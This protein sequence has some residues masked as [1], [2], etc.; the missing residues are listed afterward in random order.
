ME[1]S[2]DGSQQFSQFM[3]DEESDHH[4]ARSHT[5]KESTASARASTQEHS[6]SNI[7]NPRPRSYSCQNHKVYI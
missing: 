4:F 6:L 3:S 2:E 7:V 1:V 5:Y